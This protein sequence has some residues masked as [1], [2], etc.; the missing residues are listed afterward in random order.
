MADPLTFTEYVNNLISGIDVE[1]LVS[2]SNVVAIGQNIAE[3]AQCMARVNQEVA[4]RR[5]GYNLCL[6]EHLTALGGKSVAGAKI[7]AEASVEYAELLKAMALKESV[8]EQIR[9]L[10]YLA[11][12]M[13]EDEQ[14]SKHT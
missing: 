12:S 5:A 9:G 7:A 13:N 11:R 6:N 3:L 14:F 10:K 8:V 2:Q 4:K 1:K